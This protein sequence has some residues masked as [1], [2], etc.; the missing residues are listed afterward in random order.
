[1]L[2]NR[3]IYEDA[4]LA[5]RVIESVETWHSRP[6]RRCQAMGRIEPLAVVVRRA[7]TRP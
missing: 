5:V 7:D 1:M 3:L 6:A 2:R 4:A